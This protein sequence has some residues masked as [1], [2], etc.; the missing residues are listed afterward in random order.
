M[1]MKKWETEN[2]QK[3]HNKKVQ[4]VKPTIRPNLKI[5]DTPRPISAQN[6]T[7]L[8]KLL[9][10]FSLTKYLKRL[11]DLKIQNASFI[12]DM[13]Q[14]EIQDLI[15]KIGVNPG[16]MSKF[17]KLIEKIQ[18]NSF[19]EPKKI[20]SRTTSNMVA[21]PASNKRVNSATLPN[22]F[23]LVA[24][25]QLQEKKKLEKELELA[26]Q[27]IEELELELYKKKNQP[28][29]LQKKLPVEMSRDSFFETPLAFEECK[30]PRLT[31]PSLGKSIDSM[32]M[33]STLINLDLEELCRCLSRAILE[34]IENTPILG[35]RLLGLR[36][37][38]SELFTEEPSVPDEEGVYNYIKNLVVRGQIEYEIPIVS[39][40]YL[41]RLVAK[42]GIRLN[43]NNWKKIIFI[44]FVEASKVWDDE[45]F[46]NNSFALAFSKYTIQE[47]NRIEAAFLTLIDYQLT[48]PSSDYAKAYFLLRTYA[49]N[50]DKSF[51]LKA[52]N[53][54]IVL[55]LQKNAGK[56]QEEIN[57]NMENL[58][59]SI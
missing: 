10:E 2:S 28:I 36:H 35:S 25:A 45:S 49:Q 9:T 18:N 14:S 40:V 19:P 12:A 58:A 8:T 55:K 41:E 44:V 59:K 27:K 33:R 3:I 46:E 32:Q 4:N 57:S 47:I 37:R 48:V 1:S 11:I 34:H 23:P 15:K 20:I 54:E 43:P 42:S 17:K 16:D 53:V 38:L 50:R 13:N 30:N 21:G 39:L 29:Q 7:A 52:L 24:E 22:P 56:K 6:P 51:P 26:K 31:D 5:F